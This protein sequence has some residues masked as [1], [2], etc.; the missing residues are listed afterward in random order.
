MCDNTL[1]L[2]EDKGVS[3]TRKREDVAKI[4]E[5]DETESKVKRAGCSE[6]CC[7]EWADD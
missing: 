4:N 3:G 1:G 7:T 6:G 5:S 2:E